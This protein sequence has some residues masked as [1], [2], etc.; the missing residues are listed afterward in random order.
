MANGL[1]RNPEDD[2][3]MTNGDEQKDWIE[4]QSKTPGYQCFNRGAVLARHF[5]KCQWQS[6]RKYEAKQVDA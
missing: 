3:T 1:E 4:K 2:R 6:R 5:V